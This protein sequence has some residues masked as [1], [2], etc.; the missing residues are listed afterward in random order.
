MIYKTMTLAEFCKFYQNNPQFPSFQDAEK[1]CRVSLVNNEEYEVMVCY[2]E[3]DKIFNVDIWDLQKGD[4]LVYMLC[5][6][7]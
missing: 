2:T 4:T 7:D 1:E 5:I 6:R 3:E